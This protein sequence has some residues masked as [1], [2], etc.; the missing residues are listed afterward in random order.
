MVATAT[1]WTT[2]DALRAIEDVQTLMNDP[3]DAAALAQTSGQRRPSWRR[4]AARPWRRR[5]AADRDLDTHLPPVDLPVVVGRSHRLSA[6]TQG[7]AP[8]PC[9]PAAAAVPRRRSAR[10]SARSSAS[11]SSSVWSHVRA[12]QKITGT[13]ADG[14]HEPKHRRGDLLVGGRAEATGDVVEVRGRSRGSTGP[15]T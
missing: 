11:G 8:P 4:T 2:S 14:G 1:L 7:R 6:P 13:K 10:A 9:R 15:T 5:E 3:G 12:F